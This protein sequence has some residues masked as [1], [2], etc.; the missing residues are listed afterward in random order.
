LKRLLMLLLS[1]LLIVGVSGMAGATPE[2]LDEGGYVAPLGWG[3]VA[4]HS[5][6]DLD[7]SSYYIWGLNDLDPNAGITSIDIVF[8]G[9]YNWNVENN[10]LNVY[11][12]NNPENL[13]W[14]REGSDNQS[15]TVPDWSA[16]N[17]VGTWSDEDGSATRNDVVFTVTDSTLLSYIQG[18][19]DFGIGIDPDCHFYGEKITVQA[20]V[21]EPATMFLLGTGLIGTAAIGRR[22][23]YKSKR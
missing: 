14:Y 23:I 21:P 1:I 6:I 20:P 7:H 12:F 3:T 10:W 11:I 4:E 8:H 2:T 5:S 17:L 16:E 18:E 13:G 22:K 19:G 15:P 9:V